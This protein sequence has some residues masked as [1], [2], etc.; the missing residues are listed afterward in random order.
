MQCERGMYMQRKGKLDK[1]SDG[2][3]RSNERVGHVTVGSEEY[4][5]KAPEL[6][7]SLQTGRYPYKVQQPVTQPDKSI[8]HAAASTPWTPFDSNQAVFALLPPSRVESRKSRQHTLCLPLP[9][10]L[11]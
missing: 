4:R 2:S 1:R 9:L 3:H 10:A 6:S 5:A 8:R 7:L 11:L